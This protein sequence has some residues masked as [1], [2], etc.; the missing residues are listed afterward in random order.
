MATDVLHVDSDSL[1]APR[2]LLALSALMFV[3]GGLA[4]TIRDP[5]V[6]SRFG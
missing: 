6:S 2:W 4:V 1:K 5:D 3:F